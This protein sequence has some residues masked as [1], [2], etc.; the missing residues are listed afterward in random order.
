MTAFA[1]TG[2][3]EFP[4]VLG[5]VMSVCLVYLSPRSIEQNTV[6]SWDLLISTA[7]LQG[8]V[9]KPRLGGRPDPS[10]YN[11]CSGEMQPIVIGQ[12]STSTIMITG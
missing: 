2:R 8:V 9:G 12:Q 6:L 1:L 3:F 10:L 4:F 11:N 5:T 7:V